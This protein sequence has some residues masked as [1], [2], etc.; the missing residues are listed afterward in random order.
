MLKRLFSSFLK[1]RN[2]YLYSKLGGGGAVLY[3]FFWWGEWLTL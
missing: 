1:N 2:L 3:E